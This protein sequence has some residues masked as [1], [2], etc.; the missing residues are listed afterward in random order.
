[1]NALEI[2]K[3][4]PTSEDPIAGLKLFA[5]WLNSFDI[6]DIVGKK[7]QVSDSEGDES[8]RRVVHDLFKVIQ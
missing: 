7:E 3:A 5:G 1:M 2:V 6:R 4:F 8:I